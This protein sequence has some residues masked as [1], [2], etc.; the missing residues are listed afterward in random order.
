MAWS[1]GPCC[2]IIAL[3]AMSCSVSVS[4]MNCAALQTSLR[5]NKLP[6]QGC[7]V[8]KR[9]KAAM[10]W[11]AKGDAVYIH[12]RIMETTKSQQG[13][14]ALGMSTMG[15]MKGADIAMVHKHENGDPARFQVTDCHAEVFA[16]PIK[17]ASQ[18][19]TLLSAAVKGSMM[20]ATLT[21][22]LKPC[23]IDDDMEIRRGLGNFW[24]FANGPASGPG[25][26]G[27]QGGFHGSDRGY[28]FKQILDLLPAGGARAASVDGNADQVIIAEAGKPAALPQSQMQPPRRAADL[29][30]D[31]IAKLSEL[32]WGRSSGRCRSGECYVINSDSSRGAS[33]AGAG[34]AP[35]PKIVSLGDGK[36]Y[37]DV[38]CSSD[39]PD[40]E[41]TYMTCY[42]RM[43][44]DKRYHITKYTTLYGHKTLVHHSLVY[45][46]LRENAQPQV[47][48]L[49]AESGRGPYNQNTY[50]QLCEAFYMIGTSPTLPDYE[51]PTI[52]GLPFGKDSY[53][54]FSIEVHYNNPYGIQGERDSGTGL[55]L[56]FTERLRPN[57]IGILTLGQFLLNIPP[58]TSEVRANTSYCPTQ[59]SARF[60][61]NITLVAQ[62]LHMH[63]LGKAIYTTRTRRNIAR[64]PL[65]TLSHFDYNFQTWIDLPDDQSVLE[66]GEEL[67]MTCV[68][69]SSDRTSETHWGFSTQEEMCFWWLY[70]YPAQDGMGLCLT[71]GDTELAMCS[72]EVR[73]LTDLRDASESGNNQTLTDTVDRII[74]STRGLFGQRLKVDRPFNPKAG[75][76][77]QPP[78][79]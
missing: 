72:A 8:L 46:C 35:L 41:T 64:A 53:E 36:Y 19:W 76:V 5:L 27:L 65:A 9:G 58:G 43:P 37:T 2:W 47:E 44:T 24:I 74:N 22:R 70:Y 69:D 12:F 60:K 48:Q 57:E 17:D 31:K 62:A 45:A 78:V 42:V 10:L 11:R 23:D 4:A 13:W 1:S 25:F 30:A 56:Y 21:R 39:I 3:L 14:F 15:S 63:G 59:C 77:A 73:D 54:Y 50:K 49:I 67:S 68:F 34:L 7:L 28:M 52:T 66:P 18:D 51:F 33:V 38:L 16:T 71:L 20:S 75:C 29:P 40:A 32:R 61:Q 26:A 79:R 6:Y 55:R